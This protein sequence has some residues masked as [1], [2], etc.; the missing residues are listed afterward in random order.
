M[1][2]AMDQFIVSVSSLLL[3]LISSAFFFQWF[4]PVKPNSQSIY[5]LFSLILFSMVASIWI[6]LK[7]IDLH[8]FSIDLSILFLMVSLYYGGQQVGLIALV[9]LQVCQGLFV[10]KTT[11]IWH[12]MSYVVT[13]GVV[14]YV[15]VLLK[16]RMITQSI[17]FFVLLAAS[18]L[19]S[20]P[21]IYFIESTSHSKE[22]NTLQFILIHFGSGILI[23]ASLETIR[24]QYARYHQA[25]QEADVDGLTGLYNRRKLEESVR[26][27]LKTETTFSI[28][29]LDVDHFKRINDVYGHDQGDAI[30]RQISELLRTHCPDSVIVGRYGGE[31]FIMICPNL[32]L[33]RSYDLAEV[34]RAASS[35]Y[36][37][38]IKDEHPAQIT[39]SIGV[40]YHE[41]FHSKK[42]SLQDIVQ[43]A[44]Q[45]LYEAKR[46]GRNRVWYHSMIQIEKNEE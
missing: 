3:I 13:Y 30:L 38:Q 36:N 4:N 44:D 31:E 28:L 25:C 5:H 37:Y 33:S 42:E 39:V 19:I 29:M 17:S 14:F 15:I 40:A 6:L 41:S 20:L 22:T 11:D 24:A 8:G 2:H 45:A 10:Y 16:K 43:D 21:L 23:H 32:Q 9:S 27:L 35:I 26:Q 34:V 1:L 7:A 18:L 12:A 46:R